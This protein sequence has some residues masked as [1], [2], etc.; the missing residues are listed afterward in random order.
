MKQSD[1]IQI[2]VKAFKGKTDRGGDQY[3]NHL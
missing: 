1:A 2:I 3:V